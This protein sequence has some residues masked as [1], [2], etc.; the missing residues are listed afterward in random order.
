MPVTVLPHGAGYGVGALKQSLSYLSFPAYLFLQTPGFSC[1]SVKK[2]RRIQQCFEKRQTRPYC[3]R[4]CVCLDLGR[5]SRQSS[6]LSPFPSPFSQTTHSSKA[7]LLLTSM[8]RGSLDVW[9]HAALF[10]SKI[11]SHVR[12]VESPR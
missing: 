4:Y 10:D 5:Y 2:F 12:Y 11:I 9:T 6:L 7:V 1:R 3:L 8:V